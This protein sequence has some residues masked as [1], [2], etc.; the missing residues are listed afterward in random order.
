[1][2]RIFLA[3][4]TLIA[5]IPATSSGNPFHAGVGTHDEDTD[6]YFFRIPPQNLIAPGSKLPAQRRLYSFVLNRDFGNY[7]TLVLTHLQSGRKVRFFRKNISL[8][9][10]RIYFFSVPIE[11]E[12][13]F[14]LMFQAD[15]DASP[16]KA[17]SPDRNFPMFDGP[18]TC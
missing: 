3:L 1:M 8:T 11:I 9:R 16:P 15:Y 14:V 4:C 17:Q 5:L 7:R 6:Q 10:Q 18:K 13:T 2:N 12:Q